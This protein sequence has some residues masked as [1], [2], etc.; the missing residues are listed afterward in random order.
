MEQIQAINSLLGNKT[1][2]DPGSNVFQLAV[3]WASREDNPAIMHQLYTKFGHVNNVLSCGFLPLPIAV[4]D[5][6]LKCIRLLM[7]MGADPMLPDD[8]YGRPLYLALLLERHDAAQILVK[9]GVRCTSHELVTLC[10]AHIFDVVELCNNHLLAS[11]KTGPSTL[12]SAM[13]R[14][15]AQE[16]LSTNHLFT[17]SMFGRLDIVQALLDKGISVDAVSEGRSAL[18]VALYWEKHEVARYLIQRGATCHYSELVAASKAGFLD[19]VQAMITGGINIKS[20]PGTNDMSAL[21]AALTSRRSDVADFL[22]RNEAPYSHDDLAVALQNELV[23]VART[24]LTNGLDARTASLAPPFQ[25]DTMEQSFS[26]Q[27]I[28]S[29]AETHGGFSTL[30]IHLQMKYTGATALQIAVQKGHAD[31]VQLLLEHGAWRYI[32]LD[33]RSDPEE[34]CTPLQLALDHRHD[35]IARLLL[36]SGAD[37]LK[38]P[39]PGG[40]AHILTH[41]MLSNIPAQSVSNLQV[42]GVLPTAWH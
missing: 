30:A 35:R 36:R 19:I 18:F 8:H 28:S 40:L 17:A 21:R 34:Q 20:Q 37:V 24:M 27:S 31:I 4:K 3:L 32:D 9:H 38:L 1:R 39:R 10:E 11:A 2:I 13:Y 25:P 6:G 41:D 7:S 26:Y 22:I 42:L 15:L 33:G 14:D 5:N 23:D 29:A 16:T 12:F